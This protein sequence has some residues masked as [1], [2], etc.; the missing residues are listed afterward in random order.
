[1]PQT[2]VVD[3]ALVCEVARYVASFFAYSFAGWLFE[4]LISLGQHH[5]FVNRGFSFGPVCPIYGVGALLSLILLSPFNDPLVQF[6]VG[7]FAAGVLEF[8]TSWVMERL[9]HARWWDY[10]NIPLNLNGR[11]CVPGLLLFSALMLCVD[12]VFQP[13]LDSLY[14]M[15]PAQAL[16]LA[17]MVLTVVFAVDVTASTIRMQGFL[18]KVHGVQDALSAL[19][20]RATEA[21]RTLAP[22][23]GGLKDDMLESIRQLVGPE[24]RLEYMGRIKDIMRGGWSSYER[25][26]LADPRFRLT[27]YTEAFEW[28]RKVVPAIKKA[29]AG[30]AAAVADAADAL[31]DAAGALSEAASRAVGRSGAGEGEPAG[32][33]AGEPQSADGREDA[34][35]DGASAGTD[36]AASGAQGAADGAA[37]KGVVH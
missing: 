18:E 14:A 4:V 9:F 25:K 36:A 13:V 23:V 37:D 26:S 5:R 2:I 27:Q 1:M 15:L 17:T 31:S 29:S 32:R 10:S 20:A 7:F 34:C 24:A 19:P 35:A 28:V 8:G 6:V 3:L 16:V 21:M 30:A 33:S 12:L 11:I 22:N